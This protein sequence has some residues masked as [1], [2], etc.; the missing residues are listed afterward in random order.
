MRVVII[1][2]RQNRTKFSEVQKKR[3]KLRTKFSEEKKKAEITNITE[4]E[5]NGSYKQA[6]REQ[7][8]IS[9]LK[10]KGIKNSKE[11]V[12]INES[13]EFMHYFTKYK[14][15][16][17]VTQEDSFMHQEIIKVKRQGTMQL[18]ETDGRIIN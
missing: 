2:S 3:Q 15:G 4:E 16:E 6:D 11:V 7:R 17:I 18:T 10:Q 5:I 9:I 12:G 13:F 14:L 8:K 1:F